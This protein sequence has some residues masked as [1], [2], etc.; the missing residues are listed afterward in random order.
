[1]LKHKYIDS[2]CLGIAGAALLIALVFYNGEKI[3]IGNVHTQPGYVDRIFDDSYVHKIDLQV[4]NWDT[5]LENAK[6][7]EYVSCDVVI[8]GEKIKNAGL[9]VKG[10]NSKSLV[11]KYGLERYS[12]KLEFDHYITDSTYY[13]LDKMSLDSSFQDNSYLKNYMTY[14]MMRRMGV[15]SPLCSYA[16]ITVNG[17]DWGLYLALEEPEEAFAERNFGNDYGKL[18]KPDYKDVRA[19]NADVALK[20]IDDNV[21]SYDN[22]FRKTKFALSYKDK[23]RLIR[24][25]K[26][27]SNG[28]KLDEAVNVDEVLR[29]FTVQV[30]VVNL[31]SYLGPTGHNYYLYEKDGQLSMLPWDYNL[32]YCTYSLGKPEPVNDAGLYVNYPIDTPASGDIMLN[33]PMFHQLMLNNEYYQKY[34]ELFDA[35]IESYFESG[36]FTYKTAAVTDMIA[37]Y[38]QKDPTAFCSYEDYL[39]GVHTFQK[40]CLL[41]AESVRKQLEGVVPSTI[42]GQ[43]E[44]SGRFVDASS[45]WLPDMGEVEDLKNGV[46]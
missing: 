18:Y 21:D 25:L 31:D 23:Q 41:R 22:I 9:R 40:F 24:S 30:F 38:V 34:H 36:Y 42:R 26:D 1:M 44:D 5:F 45:I 37:P 19:E 7:E 46:R 2:I 12:L 27:L 32:A 6:K 14:D 10:N 16:W 8:D 17:E 29:Y 43:Q 4:D 39:T 35:F 15:P 13:G 3:G 28:E 33:R 11:A 20:Y